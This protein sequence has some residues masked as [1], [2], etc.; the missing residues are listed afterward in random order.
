MDFKLN[1]EAFMSRNNQNWFFI[2]AGISAAGAAGIWL[3][4]REKARIQDFQSKQKNQ[5]RIDD[6]LDDS[7]PAS[8]PPSWSPTTA[9][10]VN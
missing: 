7:F 5:D 2:L 1:K 3:W 9:G 4:K 8:D 6:T 10:A